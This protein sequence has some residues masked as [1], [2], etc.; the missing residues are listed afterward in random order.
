MNMT[1]TQ[2]IYKLVFTLALCL[3][4]IGIFSPITLQ[5]TS[6]TSFRPVLLIAHALTFELTDDE[7]A[8]LIQ[9]LMV[10]DSSMFPGYRGDQGLR[11]LKIWIQAALKDLGKSVTPTDADYTELHEEFLDKENA[12]GTSKREASTPDS[13]V[14]DFGCYWNKLVAMIA[15]IPGGIGA[16]FLT[17]I[18]QFF[19]FLVTHTIIDFK[20]T[21]AGINESINNA[22]TAF[23]DIANIVIIGMFVFIAI[24]LILGLKEYGER[25]MIARVLII[26]VL[27]NFSLL[28][29]KM[30]IDASHFVAY[31]FYQ[32]AENI[33]KD[34]VTECLSAACVDREI[35]AKK[36]V[37]TTQPAGIAGQFLLS[38]KITSVG[39]VY[40]TLFGMQVDPEG[41]TWKT[42]LYGFFLFVMFLLAGL[43][44]LYGSFL[45]V[46]RALLLIFLMITAP[47]AFASWLI[48]KFAQDGWHKWWDSLLRTAIFAPLLMVFLWVSLAVA[49][50]IQTSDTGLS[51]LVDNPAGGIGIGALFNYVFVLGLLFMSIK[52]A[53]KFSGT[54]AGFG[55]AMKFVGAPLAMGTAAA[56]W[57]YGRR[58]G[59][60]AYGRAAELELEIE[61]KKRDQAWLDLDAKRQ[62]AELMPL[63]RELGKA[64]RRAGRSYN[65]ME[66]RPGKAT[67]AGVFGLSGVLGGQWGTKGYS[68]RVEERAKELTDRFAPLALSKTDKEKLRENAVAGVDERQDVRDARE[69]HRLAEEEN[70]DLQTK[71]REQKQSRQ[72]ELE[73]KKAQKE[74]AQATDKLEREKARQHREADLEQ[75]RRQLAEDSENLAAKPTDAQAAEWSGRITANTAREKSILGARDAEIARVERMINQRNEPLEQAILGLQTAVQKLDTDMEAGAAKV[76]AVKTAH[77]TLRNKHIADARGAV[78]KSIS[79]YTNVLKEVTRKGTWNPDVGKKVIKMI[80]DKQTAKAVKDVLAEVEPGGTPPTPPTPPAA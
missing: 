59:K 10:H 21:I 70:R 22:W 47:L 33:P 36:G 54:I 53:S 3:T 39:G 67:A 28:F 57:A 50:Q 77:D 38:M 58:A 69:R 5:R 1:G 37:E 43:V 2:K 78:E 72:E 11:E 62:H 6:H 27:I 44:L 56:S 52:L 20:D 32:A 48:P 76:R 12:F 73:R 35:E 46:A 64:Q 75:I 65:V 63:T 66:T 4:L 7:R 79:N 45:L 25:K 55:G 80:G 61:K 29:T 71:L 9:Q 51:S 17:T 41:A 34:T 42:I 14:L 40:D 60:K 30:I 24:S 8:Y 26:A 19:N 16:W 18:G 15:F 31:Q 68:K 13:C 23:R 74:T 49:S